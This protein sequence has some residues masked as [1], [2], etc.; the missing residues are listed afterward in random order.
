M[1]VVP[2]HRRDHDR[3]CRLLAPSLQRNLQGGWDLL[4]ACTDGSASE[5]RRRV[6]DSATVVDAAELS[7]ALA[8]LGKRSRRDAIHAVDLWCSAARRAQPSL[9]Y[10]PRLVLDGW[11]QQQFVK[12]GAAAHVGTAFYLVLDAD[13]VCVR[14]TRTD[15][16]IVDGRA[17]MRMHER[18]P[19]T[20]IP[21]YRWAADL[22]RC[23]PLTSA[24]AMPGVFL[25][26]SDVHALVEQVA[27]R[28]PGHAVPR[29]VQALLRSSNPIDSLIGYLP[30]TEFSLYHTFIERSG[31][32]AAL[33][34]TTRTLQVLGNALWHAN[35]RS[36]WSAR[37][38]IEQH[39]PH[40]FSLVQ[41]YVGF[42][43]AELERE[44]A[45]VLG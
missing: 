10:V 3:L 34:D 13:M 15:E 18:V 35:A 7:P 14:P 42:E 41:P 43:V 24:M 27:L 11:F 16:L 1:L 25:S 5:L 31:R 26:T 20:Q 9:R 45:P 2:V 37:P 36:E 33:Y 21:W 8:Q 30:W 19:T 44:F 6:R 40:V 12:L 39:E 28:A 32:R 17:P 23:P 22:L 4:V 38:S 29:T